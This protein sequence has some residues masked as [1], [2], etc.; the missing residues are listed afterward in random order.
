MYAI[1]EHDR[2]ETPDWYNEVP[3]AWTAAGFMV[4]LVIAVSL[5]RPRSSVVDACDLTDPSPVE[6]SRPPGMLRL[7]LATGPQTRSSAP[8]AACR[9]ADGIS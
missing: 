5:A 7:R 8:S 2:G 1:P 6:P 3:S 9:S 4:P